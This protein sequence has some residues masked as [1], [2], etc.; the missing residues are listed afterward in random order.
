M[1]TQ[2]GVLGGV[3]ASLKVGDLAAKS[4]PHSGRSGVRGQVTVGGPRYSRRDSGEQ[5]RSYSELFF[6]E[7]V[8]LPALFEKVEI[9]TNRLGDELKGFCFVKERAR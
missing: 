9:V 5:C 6:C 1:G 3:T 8:P 7:Q 2:Y 4:L